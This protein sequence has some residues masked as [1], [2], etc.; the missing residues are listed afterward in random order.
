MRDEIAPHLM[1]NCVFNDYSQI[2]TKIQQSSNITHYEI[3]F[4]LIINL[5]YPPVA[6]Y[7]YVRKENG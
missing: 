5:F 6:I 4:G 3:F 1:R 7:S 2:C